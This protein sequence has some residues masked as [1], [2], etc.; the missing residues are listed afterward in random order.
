MR[1]VYL[2]IL[3]CVSYH[4]NSV[5]TKQNT[6]L[7][8]GKAVRRRRT[9][10]Y[11][12]YVCVH[13]VLKDCNHLWITVYFVH[14]FVRSVLFSFI[15]IHTHSHANCNVRHGQF[16]YDPGFSSSFSLNLFIFCCLR[17]CSVFISC[18]I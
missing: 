6:E 2:D 15:S 3:I 5:V 18:P 4:I 10:A 1:F 17:R 16:R 11:Y 13:Y 14:S 12:V 7:E 9:H 8:C